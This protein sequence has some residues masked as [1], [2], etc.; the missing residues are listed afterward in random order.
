MQPE[1]KR[2]QY[3]GRG[4]G[5]GTAAVL[6]LIALFLLDHI[7]WKLL[8]LDT[9]PTGG[10]TPAH[11]YLFSHLKRT[12]LSEGRVVSWA[13][14]WWCGFPMFRYYFPLPYLAAVLLSL[15]VPFNVAF[16]LATVLGL[17]LLPPAAWAAGRLMRLPRPVPVLLA[18]AMVP[19]L[20]VRT[21]SMWGVNISSTFAGMIANSLSFPLMLL[22]VASAWRDAQDEAIRL[23]TV[24]LLVL[25]LMSHFFTSLMAGLTIAL[26]PFLFIPKRR[27]LKTAGLLAAEGALAALMM[28]WW[29]VPLLARREFSMDFG[30]NWAISL[31]RTFP[32]YAAALLPLVGAALFLAARR[33]VQAVWLFAGMGAAAGLLLWKGFLLSPV[34]VNVRLWPFLFF[35]YL[36]LA[37]CGAGLL[38]AGRRKVGLAIAALTLAALAVVE[39]GERS[40]RWAAGSG[41][42]A[43]PAARLSAEW[44]YEGVEPKPLGPVFRQLIE[45]LRG[46]P[47]R[48]ANELNAENTAFGSVRI[49]E[50]VPHLLGKPVLEGGLVNSAIGSMFAYYIQSESSLNAAGFPDIVKPA[51]FDPARATGHF[52]LF[53]VK[54]FIARSPAVREAFAA[55]PEWRPVLA[56]EGWTLFELTTHD[57]RYV[58]IPRFQP[59][60]VLTA[61]WKEC[62]LEWMYAFE[63]LEQPFVFLKEGSREAARF[64]GAVLSEPQFRAYLRAVRAGVAPESRGLPP[65]FGVPTR[66]GSV[67]ERA[68]EDGSVAFRTAAPGQPHVAA[69]MY[70]PD[71][72]SA[73]GEVFL[74]TPGFLLVYP[75]SEQVQLVFARS[76]WGWLGLGLTVAGWLL[77]AGLG[78]RNRPAPGA[79]R[80][81]LLKFLDAV[82]GPLLCKL[83]VWGRPGGGAPGAGAPAAAVK[84]ILVIR[85]G[86]MGDMLL[87]IP[88]L[89]RF[90]ETVPGAEADVICE[91]RNRSVLE[92]AG[93]P[94][95]ILPAD[96]APFRL[97]LRLW[98]T[99]YD[100]A[101][102]TEQFHHLSALLALASGAPV[103]I[104]FKIN[105]AR[106][107]LYTHP[108]G[109]DM[110]GHE[111]LQFLR[112]FEPL[113]VTGPYRLEGSLRA[114]PQKVRPAIREAVERL[115]GEG[116]LIVIHP[117]GTIESKRWGAARFARLAE[118]LLV[119]PDRRV[120]LAGG[121]ADRLEAQAVLRLAA[122]S[123]GRLV[124]FT[125]ALSIP[126]TAWLL[127]R[128]R[129]FVGGDSGVAHLAAA[130]G[131][132]TVVLFGPG[133]PR[134]WGLTD[135]RHRIIRQALPCSPCSLFG[136]QRAC[137]DKACMGEITV[138]S[139]AAAVLEQLKG[140]A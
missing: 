54:H 117:G 130:L 104:G 128:S 30:T 49:F 46:T 74:V 68:P 9:T 126:E 16:K 29:L 63:A 53:N 73:A 81:E 79:W 83:A 47:G 13:N 17:F 134:K 121:G 100:A 111:G 108:A 97:W 95:T 3:E 23:R 122:R 55:R 5:W 75:S 116:P 89:R 14:G 40:D 124:D 119:A 39:L 42:E 25:T 140:P 101:V 113:G 137:R 120:A 22:A 61:R 82:L 27:F 98:R 31:F 59:V 51:S 60:G 106:N 38:L 7:P 67:E 87:L 37:A 15:A 26:I 105:P 99:R 115:A 57:G 71:W 93:L 1:P 10:D 118:A 139:V 66:S 94:V 109:Y 127:G 103:R 19:F 12:L 35:C 11:L 4:T 48:L 72:R 136:Y 92:M 90:F 123:E 8:L 33:G 80:P 45:P 69:Y 2:S 34:F 114:S 125:G 76:G 24:L 135:A 112:L 52:R 77:A 107:P 132:R 21:H 56:L 102:D 91:T 28:G 18:I 85:P 133:D 86:G 62:A 58:R 131:V 41:V 78:W 20:F 110:D 36:A 138:D 84:R 32:P 43:G 65:V 88:V 6:V 44:N 96:G 129:V 70:D 64:P 50:T